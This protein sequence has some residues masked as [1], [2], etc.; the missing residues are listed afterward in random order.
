MEVLRDNPLR[1][2]RG[3]RRLQVRH[4]FGR[5]RVAGIAHWTLIQIGRRPALRSGLRD[6][7][8]GEGV[9]VFAF[10]AECHSAGFNR[11]GI[12]LS[13]GLSCGCTVL[14]I[15][16]LAIAITAPIGGLLIDSTG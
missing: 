3:D 14:A 10:F 4:R 9:C 6:E 15:A 11:G 2:S 13:M 8:E 1:L 5:L 7:G 12:A 16:V